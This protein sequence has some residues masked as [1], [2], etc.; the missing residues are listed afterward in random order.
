MGNRDIQNEVEDFPS[1]PRIFWGEFS[2]L[3]GGAWPNY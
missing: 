1:K 2:D 3:D